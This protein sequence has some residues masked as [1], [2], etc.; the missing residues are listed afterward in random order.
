MKIPFF[1]KLSKNGASKPGWINK[2]VVRVFRS[3]TQTVGRTKKNQT[4]GSH[5]SNQ[6]QSLGSPHVPAHSHQA[7]LA[8]ALAYTMRK[9]LPISEEKHEVRF[10]SIS[11]NGR[12]V[13]K[14]EK[15]E[16]NGD[17]RRVLV[18]NTFVKTGPNTLVEPHKIVGNCK[19]CEGYVDEIHRCHKAGCAIAIGVC[20][21]VACLE[22]EGEVIYCPKHAEEFQLSYDTWSAIKEGRGKTPQLRAI[23][24]SVDNLR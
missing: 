6:P 21:A 13:A 18:A 8:S 5:A 22:N 2:K 19:F 23:R 14:I 10:V 20:C 11:K 3:F 16:D 9:F 17:C 15:E 7:G 1:N 4:G 12:I 24:E